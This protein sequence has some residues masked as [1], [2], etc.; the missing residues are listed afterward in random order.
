MDILEGIRIP[1]AEPI[2]IKQPVPAKKW[3]TRKTLD[4]A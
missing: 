2:F 4:H 3:V 1:K